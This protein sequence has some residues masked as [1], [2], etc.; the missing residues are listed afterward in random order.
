MRENNREGSSGGSRASKQEK[1][2]NE[3]RGG[4]SLSQ[5]RSG[6]SF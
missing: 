5:G 6:Q 2:K 1:P 3:E 4:S